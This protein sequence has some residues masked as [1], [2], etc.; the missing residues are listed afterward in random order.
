[1]IQREKDDPV[2]PLPVF[3]FLELLGLALGLKPEDLGFDAHKV[4]CSSLVKKLI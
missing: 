2:Q 4:D 1:M 3:H